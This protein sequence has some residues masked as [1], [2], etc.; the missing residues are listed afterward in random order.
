VKA[1]V[2]VDKPQLQVGCFKMPIW[3]L[4]HRKN[5]AS[6][7]SACLPFSCVMTSSKVFSFDNE[8][9]NITKEVRRISKGHHGIDKSS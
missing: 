8:K 5:D 4:E 2:V 7:L 3:H 9:E 1:T 6:G